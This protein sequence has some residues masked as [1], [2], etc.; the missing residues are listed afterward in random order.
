[1]GL[2]AGLILVLLVEV[3]L[4]GTIRR[5]EARADLLCLVGIHVAFAFGYFVAYRW[6]AWDTIRHAFELARGAP[7][8]LVRPVVDWRQ[9]GARIGGTFMG[10][11]V[12]LRVLGLMAGEV[13]SV[14][15]R[16]LYS[17]GWQSVVEATRVARAPYV[18]VAVFVV[19]L[20]FTHWFLRAQEREAEISQ[21]F[22]GALTLPLLA[23][24][25][26]DDH[27]H[28]P[29]GDAPR[30]H[31]PDDLHRRHQARPPP[32]ADLGPPARV[33]GPGHV[34]DRAVRGHQPDLH[35]PDR[36][37]PRRGRA[38]GGAEVRGEPARALE[39]PVRAGRPARR[40]ALGPR[41][42]LR[43]LDLP[44]RQE[45][46]PLA[47]DRRGAGGGDPARSSR[48]PPSPAP[49]GATTSCPTPT[50]PAATATT[51]VPVQSLLVP[52]H[53]WKRSR[54]RPSPWPDEKLNLDQQKAAAKTTAAEVS[55][56]SARSSALAERIVR[57]GGELNAM[58]S[59]EKTIRDR[60]AKLPPAPEARRPRGGTRPPSTPRPCASR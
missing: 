39:A 43:G 59:R 3:Q 19:I 47:G 34:P 11:V 48:G 52:R 9:L 15:F 17:I 29:A 23:P 26:V 33:H 18:V 13:A 5:R 41:P 37:L 7:A 56:L 45:Q 51:R 1:M 14:R 30:H 2:G 27:L 22:V 10:L 50:P 46:D 36:S 54:T 38:R 20:A 55:K 24:L 8:E 32:G 12:L 21:M 25:G 57:L 16:R 42:P 4:W 35:R 28:G 58:R 49:S 6:A 40:P 53:P 60:I 44:R 31:E